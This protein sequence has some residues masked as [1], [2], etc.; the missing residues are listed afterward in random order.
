MSSKSMG[1]S[2]CVLQRYGEELKCP[3]IVWCRS[4]LIRVYTIGY[5]IITFKH[6][7]YD[8]K[9]GFFTFQ[10]KYSDELECPAKYSE[11]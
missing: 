2:W 5:S 10:P 3:A 11:E 7:L 4:S 6:S 9:V 1:R 8:F